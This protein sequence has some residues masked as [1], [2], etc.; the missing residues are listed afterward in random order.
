MLLGYRF[1]ELLDSRRNRQHLPQ[2]RLRIL[3]QEQI[4]IVAADFS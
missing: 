2:D 4:G 3:R 1:D